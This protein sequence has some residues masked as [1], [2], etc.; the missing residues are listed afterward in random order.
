MSLSL[1][2]PG[3]VERHRNSELSHLE[4][5]N[6]TFVLPDSLAARIGHINIFLTNAMFQEVCW[7]ANICYVSVAAYII[8]FWGTLKRQGNWKHWL[9]PK[10]ECQVG[11]GQ[12]IPWRSAPGAARAPRPP[13]HPHTV[14]SL[15][16]PA[17]QEPEDL[18]ARETERERVQTRALPRAGAKQGAK[19]GISKECPPAPSPS[20]V[21]KRYCSIYIPLTRNIWAPLW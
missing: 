17:Q 21:S 15:P 18:V 9:P 10:A 13:E 16:P 19:T 11:W 2:Q 12:Q 4:K 14:H 6:S 1:L 7:V 5:T 3:Y 20:Q 8:L